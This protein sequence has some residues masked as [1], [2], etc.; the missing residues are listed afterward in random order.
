MVRFQFTRRCF[1]DEFPLLPLNPN[2]GRI[3]KT[4]NG[5]SAVVDVV[6]LI[7]WQTATLASATVSRILKKHVSVGPPFAF[8]H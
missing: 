5:S 4:K 1:E 8:L 7:T 3:R 2:I 6:S